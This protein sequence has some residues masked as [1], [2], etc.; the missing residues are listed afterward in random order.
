MGLKKYEIITVEGN[1]TAVGYITL[2]GNYRQT[3][4]KT[5]TG[6][7]V[8]DSQDAPTYDNNVKTQYDF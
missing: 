4:T 8:I 5:W 1:I 7:R 3:A 6:K 2:T